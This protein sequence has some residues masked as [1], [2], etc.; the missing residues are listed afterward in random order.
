MVV[1]MIICN[2]FCPLEIACR[3]EK[4]NQ[5]TPLYINLLC[6]DLFNVS[7]F[8]L[9]YCVGIEYVLGACTFHV[10]FFK[11][12]FVLCVNCVCVC[13][14]GSAVHI[15][16]AEKSLD[17]TDYG[18]MVRPYMD[19][20]HYFFSLSLPFNVCEDIILSAK[21]HLVVYYQ[22]CGDRYLKAV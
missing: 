18:A 1:I 21:K 13:V 20:A 5:R 11:F 6:L 9:D 22:K 8:S 2:L 12:F 14:S 15:R 19:I 7:F 4:K 17:K 10:F 16:I 3:R